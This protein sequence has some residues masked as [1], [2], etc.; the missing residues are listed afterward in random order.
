[1]CGNEKVEQA[2]QI[3]DE[4]EVDMVAYCEHQL[5]MH[6][7][8]NG[9]GFNQL[10]QGGEAV[11][12]SVV[13]HNVHENVGRIQQGGTSMLLF[14]HLTEQLD[15]NET[16]KDDSGLG[17]WTVMTLQGDGV[18]TRIVCGYNPCG[19]GKLNSRTTYQQQCRNFVTKE[20]DLTCPRKWFHDDLMH[21]L[22]QWQEKGDQLTVC[23][24]ANEDIYQKLIGKSLT[25]RE[26]LNMVEVVGEFTDKRLGPTFFRGSKPIDRIWATPDI[27]VTHACV[28]PVGFGAGDHRLFV[29]NFQEASLIGEARHRIVRFT[30]R[31]LN[32]KASNGA[33]QKYLHCLE[34]NLERINSLNGSD[35]CT[36][37]AN[38]NGPSSEA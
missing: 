38:Q 15:Y 37:P 6:H 30:S 32:T 2:R 17:R 25:K 18:R 3:H 11:I 36:Q 35:D 28:M 22:D 14:G 26:G 23:M 31:R 21:Q 34:A 24:D 7:K 20:K 1:M 4:L 27:V 5:N 19:S 13:A 10:F 12:Q 9:N 8:K 16:G 33:T 29:V